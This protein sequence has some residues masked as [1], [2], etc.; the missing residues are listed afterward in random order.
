LKIKLKG[1]HFHTTEVIEEESQEV[2]NIL[3]EHDLQD[4]FRKLQ[5]RWEWCTSV[6]ASYFEGDG[7][8]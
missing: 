8:Q 6:E 7:G 3:T 4:A 2:L 5:K 1:S